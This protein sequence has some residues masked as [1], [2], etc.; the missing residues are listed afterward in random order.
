MAI[1]KYFRLGIDIED[2]IRNDKDIFNFCTYY[3]K[4]NGYNIRYDFDNYN[5]NTVRYYQSMKG[6]SLEKFKIDLYTNKEIAKY[7]ISNFPCII[8]ND[9]SEFPDDVDYR[10]YI[11]KCRQLLNEIENV[12]L[13][14]F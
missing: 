9:N 6:K 7:G 3:N 4:E 8:C 14:L 10:F 13:S 1:N 12:Q 2:T 5:N 11:G